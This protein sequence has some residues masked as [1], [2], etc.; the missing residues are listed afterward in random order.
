MKN[1]LFHWCGLTF[2]PEQRQPQTTY[3]GRRPVV[4][5]QAQTCLKLAIKFF[6]FTVPVIAADVRKP[7]RTNLSSENYFLLEPIPLLFVA[8]ITPCWKLRRA[9]QERKMEIFV[10]QQSW[11]QHPTRKVVHRILPGPERIFNPKALSALSRWLIAVP[12]AT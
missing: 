1:S 9:L 5:S 10:S 6:I 4:A 2:K 8:P 7:H 12:G 3:C 11:L